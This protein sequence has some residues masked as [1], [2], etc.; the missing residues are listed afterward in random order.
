MKT[1]WIAWIVLFSSCSALIETSNPEAII[2]L[3]ADLITNQLHDTLYLSPS[4]IFAIPKGICVGDY[5]GGRVICTDIDL[6]ANFVF[7]NKGLGPGELMSIQQGYWNK[8]KFYLYDFTKRGLQIFDEEGDFLDEVRMPAQYDRW[9]QFAMDDEDHFYLSTGF[10]PSVGLRFNMNAKEVDAYFGTGDKPDDEKLPSDLFY[11]K[12]GFLISVF[13]TTPRILVYNSTYQVVADLDLSAYE[14]IKHKRE[15][16]KVVEDPYLLFTTSIAESTFDFTT[17]RLYVWAY[18]YYDEMAESS[19]DIMYEYQYAE[20]ALTLT[21]TFHLQGEE[22]GL[23]PL[24]IGFAI[25]QGKVFG[26]DG[27]K[28]FYRYALPE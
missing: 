19:A 2:S 26:F 28:L 22:G 12:D 20:G 14:V 11:T 23:L 25:E 4:C 21:R 13:L 27:D 7:G 5:D 16:Q 18:H 17:N 6:K 15:S 8:N 3:K 10:M 1:I 24:F 9:S